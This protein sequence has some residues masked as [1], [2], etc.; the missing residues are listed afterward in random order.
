MN[1]NVLT[2]ETVRLMWQEGL[3]RVNAERRVTKMSRED[4]F[5][6]LEGVITGIKAYLKKHGISGHRECLVKFGEGGKVVIIDF[7]AI[8]MRP[9]DDDPEVP[10]F[11][12]PATQKAES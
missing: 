5:R 9:S 4:Y 11:S 1:T 12:I 6:K 2:L 7:D 3:D 10:F 8:S